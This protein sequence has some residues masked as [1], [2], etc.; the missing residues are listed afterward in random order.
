MNKR[1]L[2]L[3][4]T[5]VMPLAAASGT[6]SNKFQNGQK[7]DNAGFNV[8]PVDLCFDNG[9]GRGA[10]GARGASGSPGA[11]GAT[12][13]TGPSPEGPRGHFGDTGPTGAQGIVGFTGPIGP[14]GGP[15]GPIG[16][17][18]PTGPLEGPPG[19]QGPTGTAGGQGTAG[20][21]LAA[22]D[23]FALMPGD[24]SAT[25]GVG[26]AVQFPQDGPTTGTDITRFGASATQFTLG[27]I[28]IYLV[29]FQVSIDE[30]GQLVVALNGVEQ[31]YT[32]VGRD[33]PTD[34]IIGFCLVETL[35][36]NT[37]LSIQNP[38][39]NTTA[40]TITPKAGGTHNVS[41]HLEIVRV[42]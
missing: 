26:I 36:V 6:N 17:T 27:P 7:K 18:G 3:F 4:L 5:F 8:K 2:V 20:G 32:V 10:P 41:A 39:S 25:V 35:A 12:G 29:L 22:A 1:L 40:L 31:A 38:A 19:P 11:R 14:N 42:K 33:T 16:P 37:I 24:N 13:I 15:P 21:A 9:C 23:F 34:Q 30:P 28:G